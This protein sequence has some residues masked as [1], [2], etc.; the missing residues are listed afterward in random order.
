LSPNVNF[1]QKTA[2]APAAD[3]IGVISKR[4]NALKNKDENAV[5]DV[6]D[7]HYSKFDD[8]PPFRRQEAEEA[9][10]NEFD[11]FKV[12]SNYE[13][14][15]KELK[16]EIWNN[17]A[18]A[19]FHL[20]YK[21]EIRGNPFDVNARVST[22]LIKKNSEWKI[23][24]EHF[25]RFP[26]PNATAGTLENQPPTSPPERAPIKNNVGKLVV[27]SGI[28]AVLSLIILPEIFGSLT[29]MLGAYVWRREQRNR[30]GLI[31]VLGIICLLVGLF[32]T[33]SFALI[34]LIPT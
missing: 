19:T 14:E 31:V 24:H 25:S 30:G 11:A 22:I 13:Y 18:L 4:F 33:A 26:E 28:F 21:G 7:D 17:M 10:K 9:L 1:E 8:W 34:D 12:L 3:I 2:E 15:I 32:F 27:L 5:R 23:M 16:A 20:H 29:I 6:I